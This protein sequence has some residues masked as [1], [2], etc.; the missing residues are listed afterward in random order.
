MKKIVLL[1][2]VFIMLPLSG[3]KNSDRVSAAVGSSPKNPVPLGEYADICPGNQDVQLC[4]T[5]VIS[6]EEANRLFGID[7]EY[8][9]VKF[10]IKVVLLKEEE[11]TPSDNIY[12]VLGN[13]TIEQDNS[14][15]YEEEIIGLPYIGDDTFVTEG[16]IDCV[17][18]FKLD[19]DDCRCLRYEDYNFYPWSN[20]IYFDIGSA[21]TG[22]T[23]T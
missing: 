5:E 20:Y 17:A 10:N 7:K 9:F 4:I 15:S 8:T 1:L 11:F 19:I 3:C 12:M 14:S 21:E 6:G 13:G 2:L 16:E 18:L 23:L 22:E